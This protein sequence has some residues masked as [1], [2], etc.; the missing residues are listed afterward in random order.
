MNDLLTQG[1]AVGSPISLLT[2][3]LIAETKLLTVECLSLVLNFQLSVM[4]ISILNP[5]LEI[6]SPINSIALEVTNN[7]INIELLISAIELNVNYSQVK[8]NAITSYPTT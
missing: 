3:G 5:S 2:Q 7:Q 4:E 6:L 1:L 8:L